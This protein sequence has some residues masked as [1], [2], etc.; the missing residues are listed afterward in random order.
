MPVAVNKSRFDNRARTCCLSPASGGSG[1][2]ATPCSARTPRPR[3]TGRGRGTYRAPDCRRPERTESQI[4]ARLSSPATRRP[5]TVLR[6]QVRP[7]SDQVSESAACHIGSLLWL[8]RVDG[9]RLAWET[10]C[11]HHGENQARCQR[12]G[13]PVRQLLSP[14]EGIFSVTFARRR[15]LLDLSTRPVI[16]SRPHAGCADRL[17]GLRRGAPAVR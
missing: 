2:I 15:D 4:Q 5:H 10:L 13:R 11:R 7:K 6:F 8:A 9:L 1:I 3:N 17:G 12:A 14:K 16:I